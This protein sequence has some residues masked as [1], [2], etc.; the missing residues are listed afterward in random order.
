MVLAS[1]HQ[2]ASGGRLYAPGYGGKKRARSVATPAQAYKSDADALPQAASPKISTKPKDLAISH[3]WQLQLPFVKSCKRLSFVHY[4]QKLWTTLWRN[5][6]APR[7]RSQNSNTA[8]SW[9]KNKQR[10]FASLVSR[11]RVIS[12]YWCHPGKA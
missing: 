3:H 8:L 10:V 12:C 2:P 4:P 11:L 7:S 6:G 1:M 5:G 9:L